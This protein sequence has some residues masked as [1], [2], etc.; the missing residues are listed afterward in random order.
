[1]LDDIFSHFGDDGCGGLF[2]RDGFWLGKLNFHHAECRWMSWVAVWCGLWFS[3][4]DIRSVDNNQTRPINYLYSINCHA[5]TILYKAA[6]I[7]VRSFVL[8]WIRWPRLDRLTRTLNRSESFIQSIIPGGTFGASVSVWC[9]RLSDDWR[10]EIHTLAYGSS[11]SQTKINVVQG[12]NILVGNNR[13]RRHKI[14]IS[15]VDNFMTSI[16]RSVSYL[17]VGVLR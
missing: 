10:V 6:A 8:R 4:F 1:M 9:V 14:V 17:G 3:V 5:F 13:L 7:E 2:I 12:T 16:G 11:P 15:D